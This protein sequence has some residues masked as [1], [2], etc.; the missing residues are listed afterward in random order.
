MN[1]KILV[2][3]LLSVAA[4]AVARDKSLFAGKT[5]PVIATPSFEEPLDSTWSIAHGTWT[6][7]KGVLHVAELPE[8][9]HVAVLHHNVPLQAAVVEC[10][11]QFD[12]PGAFYVGCDAAGKHVGR[13]VIS[14]AGMVIAEDSVKPSHTLAKLEFKA[15]PGQWYHLRVEWLGD[16]IQAN[17]EGEELSAQHPFLATPK[18]RS[19]LAVGRTAKIRD[20]QIS[21]DN[22]GGETP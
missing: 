11:F 16:K 20:L 13:V 17:L 21:G 2:V 3:V 19:W 15:K 14:P 12:G 1:T 7:E 5:L 9:K 8:N 22:T 18:S 10:D 6:P 4:I